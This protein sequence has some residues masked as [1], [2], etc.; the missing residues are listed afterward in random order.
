ME[1]IEQKQEKEDKI[2]LKTY[3][4]EMNGEIKKDCTNEKLNELV[5][6]MV[7][8]YGAIFKNTPIESREEG[9]RPPTPISQPPET[10]PPSRSSTPSMSSSDN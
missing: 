1:E 3:G 8:I 10:P 9:S 2:K 6:Q 5:E 7:N 4:I